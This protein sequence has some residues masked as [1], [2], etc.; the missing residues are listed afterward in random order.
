MPIA[1]A[2]LFADATTQLKLWTV[3]AV[4]M[5]LL[6]LFAVTAAAE[7]FVSVAEDKDGVNLRSGPDTTYDILFQLPAGYPLQ[8]LE[9]KGEWSKVRDYENDQ[10]WIYNGLVTT[11]PY[12]IVTV[13][14]GN[15][16]SGPG[17]EY[18]K[19][20]KV[21]REVIFKRSSIQSSPA[22]ST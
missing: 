9:R 7:E 22:G 4:L 6:F 21:V 12:V 16:R 20:G 14:D 19:I 18:N 15:V 1:S 10:G 13:K 3:T 5:T 2:G 11:A 17:I 8:I